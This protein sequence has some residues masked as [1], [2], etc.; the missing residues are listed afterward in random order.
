MVFS[1]M[2]KPFA[3]QPG[4]GMHFHVSL[5]AAADAHALFVPTEPGRRDA[6]AAGRGIHRRRAGAHAPAL[7]ALAAPTVNSYKRLVG[8]RVAVG[9]QLGAGLRG[10]RPE[11]PHR[12]GAHAARPL[13]VAPAR[14]QRQP[15]PGHRRADRRRARRHRPP[16]RPR[17]GLHRRPVRAAAGRRSARA[18]SRCCR[19]RLGEAVDALEADEVVRAALG[20]TLAGE[21]VRLKRAEWTEY[22]RHVS[23]WELERYAR[24]RS[25][26]ARA[27]RPC[28]EP[29]APWL[30]YVCLAASMALVGSY[31]GLSKLLVA[32]F[33][34]FLLAWLRFGI[35][36]VAMLRWVRRARRARRRCRR[37]TAGCCSGRA[38][39]ATSCSRSACCSACALTSALAAG[40]IMAAIP[41][42][43]ALLSRA[44]PAASASRRACGG[45]RLR[46][47][48]HRAAVA[49]TRR[50]GA[51][52]RPARSAWLGNLL[53]LGAVL[54]EASYVVIGK[55]LT[56]NVSAAA[57]QRARSTCGAWRWSRPRR[58][59]RR[60]A[61]TS[62]PSRRPSGR[63]WCST[64]WP[65]A[66]SRCGCG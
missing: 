50:R 46:H 3:N 26:C 5:W 53:L 38:S 8:R 37:T 56:G 34:V 12:A 60:C 36:A 40:V 62:A 30:A 28:V 2:P 16:A 57:H 22:A 39:S 7:C 54:C 35:A 20:D 4:S 48:R 21:F 65:P 17:P 51:A 59:G 47:G 49:G 63:C 13:R 23:A 55:R 14:R 11:Q 24:A 45:H 32:V 25:E 42:A 66:W 31:V 6:V 44:V 10:A 29:A 15:L 41:A 64:R 33:P 27:A 52:R 19:S 9:H 1:M 58:C 61:S 43:V 18:A